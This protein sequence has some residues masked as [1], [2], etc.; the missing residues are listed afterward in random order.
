MRI[1]KSDIDA[2]PRFCAAPE[3]MFVVD[4]LCFFS[5][6]NIES[7]CKALN[8]EYACY[9]FLQYAAILDNGGVQMRQQYVEAMPLP[10]AI[11]EGVDIMDAAKLTDEERD[12]IR[13]VIDDRKRDI[14]NA[15]ETK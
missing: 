7:I 9:Y 15:V 5:G 10:K 6:N 3:G 2:F 8:S 4:S 12:V 11:I 1:S 14:L 13:M